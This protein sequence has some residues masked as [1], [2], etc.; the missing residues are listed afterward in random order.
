MGKFFAK[1][2]AEMVGVMLQEADF[3]DLREA[4]S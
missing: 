2:V 4:Q 1:Y 3:P